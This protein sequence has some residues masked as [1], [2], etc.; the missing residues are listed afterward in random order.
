MQQDLREFTIGVILSI[1]SWET[2]ENIIVSLIIAF[3]GGIAAA[4]GKGLY[5]RWVERLSNK[6]TPKV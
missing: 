3:L 2:W 5:R 6:K 1:L 4:A